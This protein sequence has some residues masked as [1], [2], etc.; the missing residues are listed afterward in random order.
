MSDFRFFNAYI[1]FTAVQKNVAATGSLSKEV[2]IWG[3]NMLWVIVLRGKVW[4]QKKVLN[5][6]V[7]DRIILQ[8]YESSYN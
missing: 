1:K 7:L 2:G 4:K 6:I 3:E 5:A 8:F